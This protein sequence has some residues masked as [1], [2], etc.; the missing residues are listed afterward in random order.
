MQLRSMADVPSVGEDELRET[1]SNS[2][3]IEQNYK[4]N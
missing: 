4:I 2:A 1:P 3:E